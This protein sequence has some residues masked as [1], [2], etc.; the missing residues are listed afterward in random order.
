LAAGRY[1]LSV[2][3]HRARCP[4]CSG[5][6]LS[7]TSAAAPVTVTAALAGPSLRQ[8]GPLSA[9]AQQAL[10]AGGVVAGRS[11]PGSGSGA[12]AG[13]DGGEPTQDGTYGAYLPYGAS[14]S[15]DGG[16]GHGVLASTADSFATPAVLGPVAGALILALAGLHLRR[17]A[18]AR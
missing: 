15:S 4:G 16:G 5:D 8:A 11:V 14:P 9:A 3:E 2:R 17:L 13:T 10:E 6:L 7:P 18:R 1:D 12:S